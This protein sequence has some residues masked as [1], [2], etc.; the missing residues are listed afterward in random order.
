MQRPSRRPTIRPDARSCGP[1]SW[2]SRPSWRR[3]PRAS[4]P[5]RLGSWPTSSCPTTTP[6]ATGCFPRSNRPTAPV[7]R[8]G[9]DREPSLR[10]HSPPAGL[11]GSHVVG[12]GMYLSGYGSGWLVGARG[13]AG[14]SYRRLFATVASRFRTTTLLQFSAWS[15]TLVIDSEVCQSPYAANCF[16]STWVHRN[17]TGQHVLMGWTS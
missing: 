10:S 1:C 14:R 17:H 15:V 16:R 7:A 9:T 5:W 12:T 2:W 13:Q 3:S 6:P 11:S 8:C 4:P